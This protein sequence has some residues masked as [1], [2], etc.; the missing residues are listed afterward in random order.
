MDAKSGAAGTESL[1]PLVAIWRG[2]DR[3]ATISPGRG[4]LTAAVV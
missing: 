3:G 4:L 1:S 2:I